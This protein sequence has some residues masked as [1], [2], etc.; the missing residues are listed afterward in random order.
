MSKLLSV[1]VTH[2]DEHEK[3]ADIK[4]I[5]YW[6]EKLLDKCDYEDGTYSVTCRLLISTDVPIL[7]NVGNDI[8]VCEDIKEIFYPPYELPIIKEKYTYAL[9]DIYDYNIL[10][11]INMEIVELSKQEVNNG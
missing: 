7:F 3:Y 9:Y 11:R 1:K 10:S 6:N 5:P 2:I 8:D 4:G